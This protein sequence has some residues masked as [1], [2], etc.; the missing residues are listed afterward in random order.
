MIP[1]KQRKMFFFEGNAVAYFVVD[2]LPTEHGRYQ[3]VP[4]RGPWAL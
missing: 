2:M 4:L 1:E 3:Y